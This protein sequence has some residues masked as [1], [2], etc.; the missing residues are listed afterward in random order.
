MPKQIVWALVALFAVLLATLSLG[1]VLS[2][3]VTPGAPVTV[4][5]TLQAPLFD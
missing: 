2:P 3:A 1:R 5:C 4:S